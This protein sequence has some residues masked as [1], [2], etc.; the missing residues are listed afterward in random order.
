MGFSLNSR[1]RKG[2]GAGR[3]LRRRGVQE[4]G[5]VHKALKKSFL[6]GAPFYKW[7]VSATGV[8]ETMRHALIKGLPF[9]LDMGWL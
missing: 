7:R 5:L 9:G 2:I 4:V 6:K 3:G 1:L 8:D